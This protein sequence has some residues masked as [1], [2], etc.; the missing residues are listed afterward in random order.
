M[1]VPIIPANTVWKIECC[2]LYAGVFC[3]HKFH[4]LN[5]VLFETAQE[6]NLMILSKI[7]VPH[8]LGVM[9]ESARLLFIRSSTVGLGFLYED[10]HFPINTIGQILVDGKDPIVALVIQWRT[11]NAG[12]SGIGRQYHF[13]IPE[14]YGTWKDGLNDTG[15]AH[16]GA[17]ANG[18]VNDFASDG[19]DGQLMLG[20]LSQK[21]F[22]SS[23]DTA[24][25]FAPLT[26]MNVHKKFTSCSKRRD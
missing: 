1:S 13:A 23:H 25:A 15:L 2:F 20:V 17:L 8:Y 9:S 19:S 18:L 3:F 12:R 14:H 21:Q 26:H 7:L 6:M 4:V 24:G 5:K 11:G 16:Y 10:T 22:N